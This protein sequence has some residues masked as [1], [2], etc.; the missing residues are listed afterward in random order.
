VAFGAFF[1]L[2]GLTLYAHGFTVGFS[3]FVVGFLA[4]FVNAG[5]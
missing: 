3:L 5:L 1:M 2:F 4:T